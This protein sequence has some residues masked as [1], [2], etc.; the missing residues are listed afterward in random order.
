MSLGE[1]M[2]GY[3]LELAARSLRRSPGLTAL[4]M[5]SISFGVA[6]SM[7][8]YSVFRGLSG[9]PIPWKSSTLFMPQIDIWGP[10]NG[11]IDEPPDALDYAD[12]MILMRQHRAARQSAIYPIGPSL[13]PANS[14]RNRSPIPL[15]GYAVSSEFFPM[16]D[17]PFH[18][19]SGWRA[20]D[21]ASQTPVAVISEKLNQQVF[22]GGNSVGKVI[23]IDHRD[24]RIVGVMTDWNPQPRFFD[25]QGGYYSV[26]G[27]AVFLPFQT[28]V[29]VH[30]IN[31]G[32]DGCRKGAS[33]P[34]SNFVALLNSDCVWIAYMAEL[35]DAAAVHSYRQY[36]DAYA[37]DQQRAGRFHWPP[38]NRLRDVPAF[39]DHAQVVPR[40]TKVSL[41]VAQGL[42]IVC[43]VNT[44]GLLL[45][46][47][48]RRSGEIAV[49]RALGASRAAIYA[50]FLTEAAVIG[51]GGGLLGL[52]FT[53]IGVLSIDQILPPSLAAL[54]RIDPSLLSLTLLMAIAATLLAGLYPT[55]RASRVQPAW[56]LKAS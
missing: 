56:Q 24:Y 9:D 40:D 35:D 17:V 55:Y 12:A 11:F 39:L 43:L 2:F 1:W 46:K 23:D 15:D 29:A 28:S 16:L 52:I 33:D 3:Y 45:A 49:R 25:V 42:L 53:A 26:D 51:L 18:Y 54:A 34:Q 13:F 37:S 47:F 36:L 6:A 30:M 20:D 41:L 14:G 31:T 38:N 44:V 8:T 27:P 22:A 19:G 5:V 48:L 50:Q 21:D 32:W 7:T 4:M 10:G